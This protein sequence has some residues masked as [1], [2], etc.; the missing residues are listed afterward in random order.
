VEAG[1]PNVVIVVPRVGH[2]E[3][4]IEGTGE[5]CVVTVSKVSDLDLGV[6]GFSLGGLDLS[7]K[8]RI[9]PQDGLFR[10]RSLPSA[11]YKVLAECG[12][13]GVATGW[14]TVEPA[15]TARLSLIIGAPGRVHG[16]ARGFPRGDGVSGLQCAAGEVSA[17]SGEHGEFT[18]ESV[19]PGGEIELGC[20]SFGEPSR[21][22]VTGKTSISVRP[23]QLTN[24]EVFVVSLETGPGRTPSDLGATLSLT[25][26]DGQPA[27]A[28]SDVRDAGSAA[29][30]GIRDGD[31]LVAIDGVPASGAR[32]EVAE[33]YLR[34][35][36]AGSSIGAQVAR[37][38]QL[39]GVTILLQARTP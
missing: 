38:G 31:V 14:V 30:A 39:L 32:V 8:R 23:A 27:L 11:R 37:S 28:F 13:G 1:S 19:F 35:R 33:L 20:T 3:G 17:T 36:S 26:H 29:Q 12:D 2:I 7:T 16:V 24:A 4:R 5:R 18:L 6:P 22:F 25:T 10:V 9:V 15:K 34:S 21:R